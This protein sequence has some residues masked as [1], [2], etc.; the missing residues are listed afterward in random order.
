MLVSHPPLR[1]EL[2]LS[3]DTSVA[4]LTYMGMVNVVSKPFPLLYTPWPVL[5]FSSSVPL[6]ELALS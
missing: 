3:Q 4:T 1:Y 5:S 6:T 2:S